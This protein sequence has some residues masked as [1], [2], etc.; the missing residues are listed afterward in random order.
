MNEKT[1]LRKFDEYT[2]NNDLSGALEALK[3]ISADTLVRQDDDGYDM[4][5]QSVVSG[6]EC[7][8]TALI[9]DGR[10]DLTNEDF[11]CGMSAAEFALD[12]PENSPIYQAFHPSPAPRDK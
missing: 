1:A 10:C 5:I 8:V 7:A 6:Y 12:Y 4:L 9:K 11:L 2:V 3:H